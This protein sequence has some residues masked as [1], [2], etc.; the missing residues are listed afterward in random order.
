M[1]QSNQQCSSSCSCSCSRHDVFG[2]THGFL[3]THRVVCNTLCC[4]PSHPSAF[5]THA[6]RAVACC[7]VTVCIWTEQMLSRRWRGCSRAVTLWW[8]RPGSM[9]SRTSHSSGWTGTTRGCLRRFTLATILPCRGHQRRSL[10]F[11]SEHTHTGIQFSHA[12]GKFLSWQTGSCQAQ[13]NCSG[14]V[15]DCFVGRTK[16]FMV[17]PRV[18]N[19]HFA[20]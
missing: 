11:A 13:E 2:H 18:L 6:C 1:N 15:V 10:T 9:S 20:F 19:C 3:A 5:I 12:V 14:I 8:S 17:L 4:A 7:C 16:C